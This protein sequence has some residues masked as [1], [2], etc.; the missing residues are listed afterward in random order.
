MLCNERLGGQQRDLWERTG[1]NREAE[2][3][4]ITAT[5]SCRA[6]GRVGRWSDLKSKCQ[7]DLYFLLLDPDQNKTWLQPIGG[8]PVEAW[9]RFDVIGAMER[10]GNGQGEGL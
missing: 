5:V 3:E 6:L 4:Q 1:G 10:A 9:N 2:V 7:L 8:H